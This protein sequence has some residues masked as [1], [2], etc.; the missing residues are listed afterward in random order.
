MEIK[1]NK[2]NIKNFNLIGNDNGNVLINGNLLINKIEYFKKLNNG[3]FQ[4]NLLS[5]NDII[6]V[7][8]DFTTKQLHWFH[9]KLQFPLKID[10]ENLETACSLSNYFNIEEWKNEC[11]NEL[12]KVELTKDLILTIELMDFFIKNRNRLYNHIYKLNDS[13]KKDWLGKLSKESLLEY[14]FF[15][16]DKV[17]ATDIQ[18][19]FISYYPYYCSGY[20]PEYNDIDKKVKNEYG[21]NCFIL[22]GEK[23]KKYKGFIINLPSK[24]DSF[25]KIFFFPP[26]NFGA[27]SK[28]FLYVSELENLDGKFTTT[29]QMAH[30]CFIIV[31]N[32]NLD[33]I[34]DN[35]NRN[36]KW[37]W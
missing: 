34:K 35:G 27:T 2:E 1:K 10:T 22:T 15:K 7:N 31:E 30:V 25:R 4:E 11:D 13:E 23:Y 6:N 20:I 28:D 33:N 32:I 24:N 18:L 8:L 14:I 36:S 16:P 37:F 12:L 19:K 3:Q 21:N 17:S 9:A 29:G 5:N 26:E